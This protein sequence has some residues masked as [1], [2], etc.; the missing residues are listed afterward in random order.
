MFPRFGFTIYAEPNYT[1][2]KHI[3]TNPFT[4]SLDNE[5]FLVKEKV[6]GFC[7]GNFYHKPTDIDWWLSEEELSRR[8]LIEIVFLFFLC[9]IPLSI[10]NWFKGEM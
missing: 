10:Y 9:F 1:S 2:G 6:N 4:K 8:G 5:M 3:D 7:K